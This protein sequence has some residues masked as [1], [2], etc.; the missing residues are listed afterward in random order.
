MNDRAKMLT[1]IAM[2]ATPWA[3]SAGIMH[4]LHKVHHKP[5]FRISPAAA[6]GCAVAVELFGH[7][8]DD[9]LSKKKV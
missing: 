1:Y 4:V 5:L 9:L 2:T 6:I 3:A 8:N 7:A